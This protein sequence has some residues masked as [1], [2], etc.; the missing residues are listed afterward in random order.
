MSFKLTENSFRKIVREET[1]RLLGS[2]KR[3]LSEM[4][5]RSGMNFDDAWTALSEAEMA[6]MEGDFRTQRDLEDKACK[7]LADV[8]NGSPAPALDI[9]NALIDQGYNEDSAYEIGDTVQ[10]K[11]MD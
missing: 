1:M 6:E 4:S 9:A 11:Y 10:M 2:S 7:I 3:R 5:R 8:F